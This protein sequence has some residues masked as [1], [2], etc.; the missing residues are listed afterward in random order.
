MK[1]GTKIVLVVAVGE[2]GIIGRGGKLPWHLRS[3]LQHFKRLTLDKPV[4]MGRK[5]YQSIGKPLPQRT[6]IVVTRQADL[7]VPGVLFV[8]DLAAAFALARADAGQ[9][10]TNEIMV[11]GGSDI[12]AAT[13]ADADRLEVT[14]V[15]ASPEGDVSFPPI[16]ARLWREVAR[17]RHARGPHDDCD[18][19][20]LTYE[21]VA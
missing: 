8:P 21:R 3:D 17:E 5:T 4:I 18:F 19:T 20:T 13:L 14:L 7:A 11:I 15:H 9:R 12:F 10:G 6:N 16:D 2:N 1:N